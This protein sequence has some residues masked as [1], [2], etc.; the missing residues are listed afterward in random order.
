MYLTNNIVKSIHSK[1]NYNLPKH[2]TTVYDFIKALE[3]IILYD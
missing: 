1:I 2:K 3:N